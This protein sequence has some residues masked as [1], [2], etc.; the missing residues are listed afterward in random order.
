[1][2]FGGNAGH[3]FP[4]GFFRGNASPPGPITSP[5]NFVYASDGDL[6]DVFYFIGRNDGVDPWVNPYPTFI[7]TLF[8]S[9]QG[10]NLLNPTDRIASGD[11]GSNNVANSWLTFDLGASRTLVLATYSILNRLSDG[12]RAL[13]NFKVRGTNTVASFDNT[14]I[15]GASWTDIDDRVA[16]TT[17]STVANTWATYVVGSTPSAYRYIQLLQTGV[18]AL[19]DD[20]LLLNEVQLYGVLQ[21]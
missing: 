5:H 15:D 8:S 1:M 10:G 3:P 14:G 17:M 18:N 4:I 7:D 12:T 20:Y 9:L 21:F 2:A 13:R 11:P 6:N 16:D 19:G